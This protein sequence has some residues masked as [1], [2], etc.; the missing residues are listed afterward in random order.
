M[1]NVTRK[2]RRSDPLI[3]LF[4]QLAEPRR[5]VFRRE[6]ATMLVY[7]LLTRR[8]PQKAQRS[9]SETLWRVPSV[10]FIPAAGDFRVEILTAA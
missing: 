8:R 10:V 4:F 3:P 2:I 9:K 1:V 5:Q 7:C 6:G